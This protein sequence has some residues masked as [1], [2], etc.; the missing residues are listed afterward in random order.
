[1]RLD[2][3]LNKVCLLKSRSQAKSGCQSGKILLDG[4]RVKES[5]ALHPGERITLSFPQ[6][7]V[8]IEVRSLPTGNVARKD[9]Q[10]YYRV[11]SDEPVER[12][13]S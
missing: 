13:L 10:D 6:R 3:W 1:M 7:R 12:D 4:A 8:E 11:L 9:A 5:H 2:V